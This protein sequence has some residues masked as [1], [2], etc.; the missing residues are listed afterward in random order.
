MITL[1][2]QDMFGTPVVKNGE[3]APGRPFQIIVFDKY[4][5]VNVHR[6]HNNN[7]RNDIAILNSKVDRRL[8]QTRSVIIGGDFNA[9]LNYKE[10]LFGEKEF[11]TGIATNTE[12]TCCSPT[13]G[14]RDQNYQYR[15]DY[16]TIDEK[17]R[18]NRIDVLPREVNRFM[19]DHLP[20]SAIISPR[21]QTSI[22][23]TTN[24]VE[25]NVIAGTRFY[26][27]IGLGCNVLP[28]NQRL[29]MNRPEWL[30]QY[31]STSLL[32]AKMKP[33]QS[34]GCLFTFISKDNLKLID[35]WTPGTLNYVID[36]M[37][38]GTLRLTADQIDAFRVF[39]GYDIDKHAVNGVFPPN[40]V[41]RKHN[42]SGMIRGVNNVTSLDQLE[43]P[44]MQFT[45][46]GTTALWRGIQWGARPLELNRT[47]TFEG[48]MIVMKM[49]MNIFPDYDGVYCGP[50]PSTYHG[51]MF[52]EEFI[53]FPKG[54]SKMTSFQDETI[55]GGKRRYTIRRR[56]AKARRNWRA[57]IT[58]KAKPRV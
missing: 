11:D 43:F 48:D 55:T 37:K 28:P 23:A 10:N 6:G 22:N 39:S 25:A 44:G 29:R 32:Y 15:F 8:L 53:L 1:Y 5:V 26:R 7:I 49:L 31:R 9:E 24:V 14:V 40:E 35:L 2:D 3:F 41:A 21:I 13:M 34:S 30:S 52:F 58:Q 27:G 36:M 42:W 20:V 18:F 56:N 47:S 16:I 4:I 33:G 46:N 50:T 51:A 45:N 17:L 57:R 19:S 12:K 38:S 54:S